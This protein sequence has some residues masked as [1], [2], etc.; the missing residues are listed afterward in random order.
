M[1]SATVSLKIENGMICWFAVKNST[2]KNDLFPINNGYFLKKNYKTLPGQ[3]HCL[4][5][6]LRLLFSPL[7]ILLNMLSPSLKES[8]IPEK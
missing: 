1:V 8:V 3:S 2:G 7:P 4:P 6:A 5:L